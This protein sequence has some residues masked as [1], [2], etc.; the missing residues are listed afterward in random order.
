MKL[1]PE[2][3]IFCNFSKILET[4]RSSAL[5]RLYATNRSILMLHRKGP[6]D[7]LNPNESNAQRTWSLP[8]R[9]SN[10]TPKISKAII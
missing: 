4:K 2:I 7:K 6:D 10:S 3:K 9:V 5:L 1:S 8:N